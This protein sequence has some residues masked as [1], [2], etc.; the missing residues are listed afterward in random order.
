LYELT[1]TGNSIALLADG[2]SIEFVIL[3]YNLPSPS[4]MI[5]NLEAVSALYKAF[6]DID[7]YPIILDR[8]IMTEVADYVLVIDNLCTTYKVIFF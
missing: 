3:E 2:S 1:I 4:K 7:A 8:S 5:P 6:Y